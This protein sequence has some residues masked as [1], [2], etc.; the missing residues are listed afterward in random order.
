MIT[1]GNVA[2]EIEINGRKFSYVVQG[3]PIVPEN[4][5]LLKNEDDLTINTS[6]SDK[7]YSVCQLFSDSEYEFFEKEIRALIKGRLVEA[8]LHLPDAFQLSNYHNLIGSNNDLHLKAIKSCIEIDS[9]CFPYS[10][11]KIEQRIS[12]ILGIQ[13]ESRKPMNDERVFHFRIIR[14]GRSDFNPFHKDAWLDE[15]KDAITIYI[16]IVGSNN[17]S[18]LLIAEG[19]HLLSESNFIRTESGAMMNDIKFNVPGLIESKVSLNFVRPN[20][21]KNQVLTFSPYLIHGGTMNLNN[22]TTRISLEM[23]F[24]RK[25]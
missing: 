14:P 21:Q 2:M 18:S 10:F 11:E 23:R 20:P 1:D 19:S 6:W 7:G 24:W 8:R 15:L 17:E 9:D 13:V 5:V 16:P 3:K 22:D 4:E 12:E 25:K